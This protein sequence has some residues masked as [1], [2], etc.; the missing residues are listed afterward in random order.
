MWGKAERVLTHKNI[1]ESKH[2][3][4]WHSYMHYCNTTNVSRCLHIYFCFPCDMADSN[5]PHTVSITSDLFV[6]SC[7]LAAAV[8]QKVCC[9]YTSK[10]GLCPFS[11]LVGMSL[12]HFTVLTCWPVLCSPLRFHSNSPRLDSNT[13][14]IPIR[15][16]HFQVL[17]HLLDTPLKDATSREHKRHK[18]KF[19]VYH[20]LLEKK[21]M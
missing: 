7:S 13:P 4:Y 1:T 12:C 8:Q 9:F 2:W 6:I 15:N 3:R 20:L 10:A 18:R 5:T 17:E 16:A 19:L 11:M 21:T 14:G